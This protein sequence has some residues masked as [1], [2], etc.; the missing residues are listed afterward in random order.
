MLLI[1]QS[2]GVR[3]TLHN[4]HVRNMLDIIDRSDNPVSALK[5]AMVEPIFVEFVDECLKVIEE[6]EDQL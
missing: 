1:E 2:E 3:E 6:T 4:P 5:S